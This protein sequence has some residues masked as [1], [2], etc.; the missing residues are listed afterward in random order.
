MAVVSVAWLDDHDRIESYAF[1]FDQGTV[2]KP[3]QPMALFDEMEREINLPEAEWEYLLEWLS[4]QRLV[5]HNAKFD[6]HMLRA[7]T[8]AWAGRDLEPALAWDTMIV[9]REIEPTLPL[10]LKEIG[11]RWALLGGGEREHEKRL[12]DWLR[13]NKKGTGRWD[14]APWDLVGPYAAVD[15]QIT[16]ALALLQMALIAEGWA[17]PWLVD[18]RLEVLRVLYRME[19][20]GI[21]Y[22]AAGSLDVAD[23]ILRQIAE[24]EKDL[25]F[26]NTLNAAKEYFFGKAGDGKGGQCLP[27][28]VTDRGTPQLDEEVLRKMVKDEVPWAAEYAEISKMERAVSMWYQGYPEKIGGDGRL[29][30]VFNQ[31]KVKS[32]RMSSER[33]NL[34]A[35]PKENKTVEGLP[36]VRSFIRAR[37]GHRLWN[38]DLSQAELR[39]AAR[40]AGCTRM[41]QM[42]AEGADLHSITTQQVMNVDQDH[43][44]FKV[45]RDIGKRLTFGGIFQIGGRTF[46]ATLSKLTGIELPLA[47]CEHFVS[48]WRS[49]YP[50]FGRAYRNSER[51]VLNNGYMVLLPGTEYESRSWFGPHDWPN[52]GWSRKVQGSLAEFMQVWLV[53]T[54]RQMADA[55]VSEAMVLSVH[56]SI[57]LE[58]P[59]DP[60]TESIVQ[61]VAQHGA[62]RAT[63]LFDIEMKVDWGLWHK[64]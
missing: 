53:E 39:V 62:K 46:Q 17:K 13:R 49:M 51:F 57:V 23:Q 29:R 37:E 32:G 26:R 35:I 36:T 16:L 28:K 8:R 59:D 47:E 6:L 52:T 56:D 40:Y 34:Q 14:L 30:T 58:L 42:L 60:D 55:G 1:P 19:R 31:T 45:L 24:R 44:N 41:M 10:G 38:L 9:H 48:E 12:K 64:D 54:E 5:F 63:E 43:P 2:D 3:G 27:Y 22:D 7:G 50:E 61:Q 15:A 21:G 4:R 25:P 20:R 33:M 11:Q 18:H